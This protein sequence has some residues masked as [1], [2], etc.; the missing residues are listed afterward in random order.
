M[1]GAV[2]QSWVPYVAVPFAMGF[3]APR[4][5]VARAGLLGALSSLV[6]VVAFYAASDPARTGSYSVDTDSIFLEYG[7]LGLLT[8]FVLAVVSRGI[9]PTAA[10]APGRWVLA[11]CSVL[12]LTL[13]ASWTLIGWGTHE[14]VIPSGVMTIGA[15][16]LDVVA[17]SAIVLAFSYAVIVCAIYNLPR[18]SA[19]QPAID[20]VQCG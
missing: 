8:G 10:A 13:I 9:A 15:S 3:A 11:C 2:T 18:P 4:T 17:S 7:P 14:V 19:E 16:T 6:L 5:T 12:T 1:M 20:E